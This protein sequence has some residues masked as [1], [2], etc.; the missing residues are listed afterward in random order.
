M[1]KA[2]H[3]GSTLLPHCQSNEA[4]F[5]MAGSEMFHTSPYCDPAS[6]GSH[7]YAASD[8]NVAHRAS[9]PSASV[10][11]VAP[12]ENIIVDLSHLFELRSRVRRH[13]DH[14][15]RCLPLAY[16]QAYLE[17]M[18]RDSNLVHTETDPLQFVRYCEYDLLAGAKRLC[19]YWT[20][21]QRLFGPDRAFLPLTLT[22]TGALTPQDLLTLQAGYPALLPNATTGHGC[23]LFDRRK[24]LPT[25]TIENHLR[26]AF[27]WHKV[28]AENDLSQV[29]Y[30][31][32]LIVAVTPRTQDSYNHAALAQLVHRQSLLTKTIFPVKLK[33]HIL[34]IPKKTKPSFG[35]DVLSDCVNL[36][37][38][39]FQSW[40]DIQIREE[41]EPHKIL[42]ELM[43]LGL[44]QNGIP[45]FLGGEWKYE[46]FSH[47]CQNRMEQEQELYMERLVAA[48][49]AV[50]S[51]GHENGSKRTGHGSTLAT[52]TT[53]LVQWARFT[54]SS[55]SVASSPKESSTTTVGGDN[56]NPKNKEEDDRSAKRKLA[57]RLYSRQ[58]RER[59]RVTFQ[60]LKEKSLQLRANHHQLQSEHKRLERLWKEAEECVANLFLPHPSNNN[61]MGQQHAGVGF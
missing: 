23:I 19:L 53:S 58:K 48:A 42:K 6:S 29:E 59:Q 61:N 50:H 15:I 46:D 7:H 9:R 20:E 41:T 31:H 14:A 40:M 32:L 57:D 35:A 13:V 5:A 22:G 27:Y 54:F 47:W 28:L 30:A 33:F 17:A 56:G 55:C 51:S 43:E 16:S 45:N 52:T 36:L 34:G 4:G 49:A 44:T 26:C 11:D 2:N 18:H 60:V 12:P 21:R 38:K 39:Y 25:V 1:N 37:R 10:S 8:N 3:L 24:N